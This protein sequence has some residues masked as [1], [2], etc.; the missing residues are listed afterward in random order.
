MLETVEGGHCLPEVVEV[1]E[2]M[3]C[4]LLYMLKAV[5]GRFCLL[6]M[7]E[8]LVREGCTSTSGR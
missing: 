4:V 6:E 7:L 3:C 1:V 2:M 8:T 5:E